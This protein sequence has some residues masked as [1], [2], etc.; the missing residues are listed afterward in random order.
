MKSE[1]KANAILY[2]IIIVIILIAFYCLTYCFKKVEINKIV[3]GVNDLKNEKN[4][5]YEVKQ[6]QEIETIY[7]LKYLN[8]M[9]KI[10]SEDQ[11]GYIEGDVNKNDTIWCL[12][13]KEAYTPVKKEDNLLKYYPEK[14]E[15]KFGF[16][17]LL[18]EKKVNK[19][20]L[21]GEEVVMFKIKDG[22]NEKQFFVDSKT[23]RLKKYVEIDKDGKALKEFKYYIE[24]GKVEEKDLEK[25]DRNSF[26]VKTSEDFEVLKNEVLAEKQDKEDKEKEEEAKDKE[27]E[28][29]QESEQQGQ[30]EQQIEKNNTEE[31]QEVE[32]EEG[33]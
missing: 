8:G 11:I 21:D 25:I 32:N 20:N 15:F 18:K 24:I 3:K 7:K 4:Y 33:R 16:F 31:K 14:L 27:K 10:N 13:E 23:N 19:M 5:S 2:S 12:P 28:T 29:K 1:K 9:Y 6:G 17:D 26:T 30:Q 22:D